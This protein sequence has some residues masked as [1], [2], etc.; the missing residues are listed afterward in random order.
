MFVKLEANKPAL[1]GFRYFWGKTVNGFDETV[2]CAKCLIGDYSK[3]IARNMLANTEL[4]IKLNEGQLFYICGVSEPYKWANNA[5][6]ALRQ[7]D[8][9]EAKLTLYTGD[10]LHIR[11]AEQ[12]HFDD[13]VAMTEYGHKTKAFTTCRNFQF[14]AYLFKNK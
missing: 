11:G 10:I 12:V 1:T 4:E 8:G 7:K 9:A 2:H 5:H 14:G 13:S 6:I 3:Q